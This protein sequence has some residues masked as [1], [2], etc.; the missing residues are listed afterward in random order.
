MLAEKLPTSRVLYAMRLPTLPV[1]QKQ[2]FQTK[3]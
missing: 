2:Y 1:R 3:A